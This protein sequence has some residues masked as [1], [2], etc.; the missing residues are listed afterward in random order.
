MLKVFLQVWIRP[1]SLF[2]CASGSVTSCN[3]W[4]AWRSAF[5]ISRFKPPPS[6]YRLNGM[7]ISTIA[8]WHVVC[9]PKPSIKFFL[10][11]T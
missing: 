4:L 2:E 1:N 5:V 3:Y 10:V 11:G 7:H 8:R 6:S 9:L